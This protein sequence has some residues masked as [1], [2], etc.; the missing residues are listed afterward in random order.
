[1]F[2]L[3]GGFKAFI[4]SSRDREWEDDHRIFYEGS[5]VSMDDWRFSNE[6]KELHNQVVK[7]W[8]LAAAA[9]SLNDFPTRV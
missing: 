4:E 9:Q 2:V 1:M 6:T 3:K 8:I 5:F 7:R